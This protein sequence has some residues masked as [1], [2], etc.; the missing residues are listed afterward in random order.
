MRVAEERLGGHEQRLQS[1]MERVSVAR[2]RVGSIQDGIMSLKLQRA[3]LEEELAERQGD[4]EKLGRMDEEVKAAQ[5]EVERCSQVESALKT[6]AEELR[7]EISGMV[8]RQ[9]ALAVALEQSQEA[10]ARRRQ[11]QD[12]LEQR[13]RDMD[14]R[15]AWLES[16]ELEQSERQ[17]SVEDRENK[18]R[19]R[20]EYLSRKEGE[21]KGLEAV[22][23]ARERKLREIESHNDPQIMGS[24]PAARPFSSPVPRSSEYQMLPPGL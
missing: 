5:A 13:S 3:V 19:A 6:S 23:L 15:E 14:E 9:S 8:E 11:E 1:A 7:R 22:L 20:E 21:L 4:L 18:F 10:V 24:S 16:R 2:G 17:H 12:M